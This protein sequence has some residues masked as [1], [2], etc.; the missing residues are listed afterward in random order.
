ML[1][2]PF[3]FA[4]E[5]LHLND[6]CEVP[7]NAPLYKFFDKALEGTG[8]GYEPHEAITDDGYILTLVRLIKKDEDDKARSRRPPVLFQHGFSACS[9]GWLRVTDPNAKP[10]VLQAMD[11]GFDVWLA[12]SRGTRYS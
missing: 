9:E 4:L 3:G 6:V 8:Y 2:H 10:T 11:A 5:H 1:S 7:Y 12:N